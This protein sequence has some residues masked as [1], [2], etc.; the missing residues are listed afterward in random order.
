MKSVSVKVVVDPEDSPSAGYTAY[1]PSLPGC[2]ANG[3]TLEEAKENMK[4][5]ISQHISTLLAH[6]EVISLAS[7]RSQVHAF[8]YVLP[9]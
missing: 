7:E 4:Q 9:T 3:R 1:S 2:Y 8:T 5:A 6:G